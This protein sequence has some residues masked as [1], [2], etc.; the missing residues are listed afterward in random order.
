MS[1]HTYQCLSPAGWGIFVQ[2]AAVTEWTAAMPLLGEPVSGRV[3]LDL[4]EVRDAGHGTPMPLSPGEAQWLRFGLG[5][6]APRI[7]AAIGRGHVLVTVRTLKLARCDYQEEG[8]AAALVGWAVDEFALPQP[9]LGVGY[10]PGT[11]R[12]T[13]TWD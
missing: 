1:T 10:E 12:Y 5:W 9:R 3:W 4:S 6:I 8:L 13:F 2:L 11:R 7:E